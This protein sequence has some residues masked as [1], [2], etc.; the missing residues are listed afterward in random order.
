[1]QKTTCD[2]LVIGLGPAGMAVSIMGSS[3]GMNVIAIEKDK[4]GG[5]CQNVGC[6]PSKALLR[7]AKNHHTAS[8]HLN[9]HLEIPEG[10]F[11]KI[12]VNLDY[13]QEKKTVSMFEKVTIVKGSA[14][15]VSDRTVEVN[16]KLYEGIDNLFN[17]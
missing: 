8:K 2:L 12:Q 1:M 9:K 15:F 14:I 13:I 3:M 6:I 11:E 7:V 5:E 4:L 16:G 10:I 17:I